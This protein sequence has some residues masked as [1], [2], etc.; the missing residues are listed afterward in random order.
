[1]AVPQ[2]FERSAECYVQNHHY[3]KP[4]H[5]D[6][7]RRIGRASVF[8]ALCFRNQF[9]QHDVEY[10][11]AAKPI[12]VFNAVLLIDLKKTSPAPSSSNPLVNSGSNR[13]GT[14]GENWANHLKFFKPGVD[15]LNQGCNNKQMKY[16]IN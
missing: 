4:D 9:L 15:E 1:M 13:A 5:A 7:R 2:R 6:H 16:I 14:T 11:P 10:D 8:L 3:S 12:I